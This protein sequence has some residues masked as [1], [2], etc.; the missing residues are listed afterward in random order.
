MLWR[1][2]LIAAAVV[3]VLST[4]FFFQAQLYDVWPWE[5]ILGGWL[6]YLLDLA[7]VGACVLALALAALQLRVR[8][9][10]RHLLFLGAIALG[11][12]GGEALL[13]LRA[14]LPPD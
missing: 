4:Q 5:D 10:S 13:L 3:V 9:R 1:G 11:A 14:P 6:D 7:I 8:P 12:L 2:G